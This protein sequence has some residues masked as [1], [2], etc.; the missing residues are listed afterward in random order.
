MP[1]GIRGFQKGHP[2]FNTGKTHFKKGL[3]PWNKDKPGVMPIPWNKGKHT[4]LVPRSVFKKGH[5]SWN[6]GILGFM[7]GPNKG[8]KFSKS[9]IDKLRSSHLGFTPSLITRRKLS[10]VARRGDKSNLWKGGINNL[11]NQIRGCFEYGIWKSEVFC[12]D[13]YTCQECGDNGGGNLNSHHI[14]RFSDILKEFLREYNRFSPVDDKEIL[15]R[16][17]LSYKPF[18]DINNGITLCEECHSKTDSYLKY[19]SS[20]GK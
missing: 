14:K 8:K 6:K 12:R 9:T 16:L 5:I 4:G 20:E 1:K 2:Q 7:V 19:T 11:T 15:V 10:E 13:D 3:V 17:S 18:W